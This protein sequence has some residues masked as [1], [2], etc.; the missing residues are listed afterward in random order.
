MTLN[1][2]CFNY[3]LMYTNLEAGYSY[4]FLLKHEKLYFSRT[5][6]RLKNLAVFTFCVYK[7]RLRILFKFSNNLEFT[8]KCQQMQ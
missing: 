5:E 2:I 1:Q 6:N 8:V 4:A 3:Q 7:I